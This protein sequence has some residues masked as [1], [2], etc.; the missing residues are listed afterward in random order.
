MLNEPAYDTPSTIVASMPA[1]NPN[2]KSLNVQR[3]VPNPD[4]PNSWFTCDIRV[5][6]LTLHLD[7]E[8]WTKGVVTREEYD[9]V[10][11]VFENLAGKHSQKAQHSIDKETP[12]TP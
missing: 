4:L 10:T 1:D 7:E 11:K 8:N 6:S 12:D 3:T 2:A 9:R 5:G